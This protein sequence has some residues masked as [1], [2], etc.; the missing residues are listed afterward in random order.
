MDSTKHGLPM[1]RSG[2]ALFS[3]TPPYNYSSNTPYNFSPSVLHS[4][5]K[6]K[7][8]SNLS[9]IYAILQ[10]SFVEIKK[11]D[12]FHELNNH[13]PS[14]FRTI[15][16]LNLEYNYSLEL[17]TIASLEEERRREDQMRQLDLLK[18]KERQ[19]KAQRDAWEAIQQAQERK[20]V[21]T[22]LTPIK[23]RTSQDTLLDLDFDSPEPPIQNPPMSTPVIQTRAQEKVIPNTSPSKISKSQQLY[24]K[25]SNSKV[26]KNTTDFSIFEMAYE[27]VGDDEKKLV[28]FLKSYEYI[29]DIIKAPNNPN[30]FL[31]EVPI[32]RIQQ[33][34]LL[35]DYDREKA[36]VFLKE[37][38]S[39][40]N[41]GLSPS[42]KNNEVLLID[43]L[44]MFDNDIKL[45]SSYLIAFKDLKELGFADIKIREA[46]VM[47]NI[48][49]ETAAQY[50]LENS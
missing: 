31:Y 41:A 36:L 15:K 32:S 50:L 2:P 26:I 28:S 25:L 21:T 24:Q 39:L 27:V 9:P 49:P 23:T 22:T 4:Y 17:E 47:S 45:A 14:S 33:A 10:K 34:L 38:D 6:S 48:N 19:E 29:M 5:Q 18:R 20:N 44:S 7:P 1:L 43:A 35:Y 40:V 30:G 16:P 12:H 37:C 3:H 46:L 8:E 42:D 13:L 11:D